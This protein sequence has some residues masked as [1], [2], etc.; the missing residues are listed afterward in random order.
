MK[1]FIAAALIFC[2][3]L[4]MFT[5]K[6]HCQALTAQEEKI[7]YDYWD[8]YDKS[9]KG[10]ETEKL[11]SEKYGISIEEIKSI[12]EKGIHRPIT[13]REQSIL[14]ALDSL[15]KAKVGIATVLED[16]RRKYGLSSG[17]LQELIMRQT[18]LSVEKMWDSMHSS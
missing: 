15:L 4:L 17:A 1:I 16:L 8:V 5:G 2:A 12:Y 9:F 10:D 18:V 6:A 14:D 13:S 7:Y 3:G 11:I